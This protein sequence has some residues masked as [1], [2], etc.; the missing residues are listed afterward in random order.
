M[1][2]VDERQPTTLNPVPK[3]K[4]KTEILEITFSEAS[5]KIINHR[6]CKHNACN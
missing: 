2:P 4:Q 1:K 5:R 3:M 6:K